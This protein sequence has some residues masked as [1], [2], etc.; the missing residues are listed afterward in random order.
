MSAS[1]ITSVKVPVFQM[2]FAKVENIR[3]PLTPRVPYVDENDIKVEQWKA[4]QREI[5][6]QQLF[7]KIKDTRFQ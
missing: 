5:A 6:R 4:Q 1:V 7:C 3:G 2:T